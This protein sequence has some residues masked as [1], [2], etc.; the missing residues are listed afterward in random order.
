VRVVPLFK[1]IIIAGV[2][3]SM[4]FGIVVVSSC[5]NSK[6]GESQPAPGDSCQVIVGEGEDMD[7]LIDGAEAV[8]TIPSID[9][10]A[11]A[12]VET[13]TFALG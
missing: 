4:V 13:A 9:L 1:I 7:T 2:L 5:Q 11:P 6:V 8:F 3:I 12:T 10:L